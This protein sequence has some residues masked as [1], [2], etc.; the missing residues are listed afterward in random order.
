M[1][2]APPVVFWRISAIG[3]LM[4]LHLFRCA[5]SRCVLALEL[6]LIDLAVLPLP[7]HPRSLS[8]AV[9]LAGMGSVAFPAWLCARHRCFGS[10][11]GQ[12]TFVLHSGLHCDPESSR[13][14]HLRRARSLFPQNI[15]TQPQT[16][17]LGI[18]LLCRP[19]LFRFFGLA[20]PVLRFS[21]GPYI[22]APL[23]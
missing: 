22:T 11:G 2:V 21:S 14:R 9:L 3:P 4:L 19:A 10:L 20:L 23:M 15:Q 16:P 18:A 12:G 7:W 6:L 8:D 17:S 5:P 13:P 1:R